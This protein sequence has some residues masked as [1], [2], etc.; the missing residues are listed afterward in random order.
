MRPAGG[1]TCPGPSHCHRRERA[2]GPLVRCPAPQGCS[3]RAHTSPLL[4]LF[5]PSLLLTEA[6]LLASL[7]PSVCICVTLSPVQPPASSTRVSHPPAPLSEAQAPVAGGPQASGRPVPPDLGP[8][9]PWVAPHQLP[10]QCLGAPRNAAKVLL[11]EGFGAAGS[12]RRSWRFPL[13]FSFTFFSF[14]SVFMG[15]SAIESILSW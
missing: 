1:S 3:G 11:G 12:L 15:A 4:P 14:F 9:A 8:E 5:L 13:S 10:R 7:H 6:W 2:A